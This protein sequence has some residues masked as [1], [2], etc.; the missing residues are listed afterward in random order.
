MTSFDMHL[1]DADGD[2]DQRVAIHW[3]CFKQDYPVV[4]IFGQTIRQDTT[5]A[6]RP[7][8]YKIRLFI[9]CSNPVSRDPRCV[10]C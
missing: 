7:D 9:H 10:G 1:A 5:G 2:M 8:N 3:T 6:A 4:H